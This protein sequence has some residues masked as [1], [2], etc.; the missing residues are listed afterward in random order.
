MKRLKITMGFFL[1]SFMVMPQI[2]A[3]DR[4][5]RF[6]TKNAMYAANEEWLTF[7]CE[8][9]DGMVD[10]KS[11][12]A[13]EMYYYSRYGLGNLLFRSGLGVHMVNNPLFEKHAKEDDG[14]KWKNS[15]MPVMGQRK[16][17]LHK[18][19]QFKRVSGTD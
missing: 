17:M 9:P 15:M 4:D 6:E 12:N 13:S 16:F 8:I 11:K 7:A 14:M 19:A 5:L 18:I 10:I 2:W 1:L 3:Q